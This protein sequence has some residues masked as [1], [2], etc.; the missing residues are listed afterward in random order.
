MSHQCGCQCGTT[1]S[2]PGRPP[3]TAA[4]I[5]EEVSHRFPG[6][7]EVLKRLGINHCCGAHLSLEQAAA[8][9]GVPL[10]TLLAQ[11]REVAETPA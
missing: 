2:V 11:L 10:E 4:L 8:S 7:L 3:I 9:A 1:A 6:A 5:V